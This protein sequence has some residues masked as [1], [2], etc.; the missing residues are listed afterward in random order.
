[1]PSPSHS[2]FRLAAF[3]VLT[4]CATS[5][6]ETPDQ[7]TS[8]PPATATQAPPQTPP[9]APATMN[10]VGTYDFTAIAPDGSPMRGS[11]TISGSPGSY[12]GTIAREGQDGTPL[13][14]ITVEGQTMTLSANIPEGTVVLTLNFTG[15]DFAGTWAIQDAG[16]A[17]T[18][19]RR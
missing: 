4:A 11:F 19:R 14:G 8:Q 1:M 13:T 5:P 9:T 15:N 16:G 7:P 6:R 18:G 2:L 12:S 3:S 10:A 17:V